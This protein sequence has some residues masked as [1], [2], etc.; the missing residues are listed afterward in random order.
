MY[1]IQGQSLEINV[2]GGKNLRNTEW[3]S[4]Q[5]P[6]V[7]VEYGT[8]KHRT[9]TDTDGGKNPSFND[10]FTLSLIEGLREL[11]VQVW[12]SNTLAMDDL[13]GTGRVQ[14]EKVISSGY[15]DNA[16]PLSSRSGKHAGELRL[17]MHFSQATG[18]KDKAHKNEKGHME[19]AYPPA[20]GYPPAP[21]PGGYPPP[22]PHSGGYPPAPVPGGYPQAPGHGYPPAPVPGGYPPPAPG[23]GH[24]YPPAPG[25]YPPAG[26]N[27]YP[28]GSSSSHQDPH[29]KPV[30]PYG[31]PAPPHGYPVV[32]P[33]FPHQKHGSYGHTPGGGHGHYS[34]GKH[35][36]HKHAKMKVWKGFKKAFK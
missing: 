36:K 27:P 34:H 22:P 15:D 17:I 31:S 12:N 5:D 1:G 24:G 19:S 32:P 23:G 18:S 26:Y 30:A 16:W 28:Q 20:G 29:H 4:R 3:L 35:K 8:Q 6:Y 9:K 21:F 14:L 11:H 33:P 25:G 7:I 10:K 13:I 2:V